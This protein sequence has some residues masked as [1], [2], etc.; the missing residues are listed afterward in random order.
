MKS[1]YGAQ[2][3]STPH[4][5][6]VILIIVIIHISDAF[7]IP[8]LAASD[9]QIKTDVVQS[10]RIELKFF[11]FFILSERPNYLC[12]TPCVLAAWPLRKYWCIIILYVRWTFC[13][14]FQMQ[15]EQPNN[16][17][18]NILNKLS[19]DKGSSKTASHKESNVRGRA[20]QEKWLKFWLYFYDHHPM[21][22]SCQ[23]FIIVFHHFLSVTYKKNSKKKINEKE[24]LLKLIGK[25]AK[26]INR[27]E[28]CIN[29]EN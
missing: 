17:E 29:Q 19:K 15:I 4:F 27:N 3:T 24:L 12:T 26:W 20:L 16:R 1:L 8:K 11:K 21:A 6:I 22:V 7:C 14:F 5:P 18:K 23:L 28:I 25:K 2:R 9:K 10:N 13:I